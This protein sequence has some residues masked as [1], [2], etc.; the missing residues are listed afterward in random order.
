MKSYER[1]VIGGDLRAALFAYIH[2]L[3]LFFSNPIAPM[4]FEFFAP[5]VDISSLSLE[6]C[7][8]QLRTPAGTM[9]VG[10]SKLDVWERLIFLL[11]LGGNLPL[12]NLCD[13]I[14]YDGQKV[15]CTDEYAK[16][17]EFNFD[18]CYYFGDSNT[19]NLSEQSAPTIGK[20]VCYDYIA[21]HRGGKQEVDYISTSDDF[22][23]EIWLYSSDRIDGNTGVKD[24]CVVSTLTTEQLSD[25][26]YSQT[27]ARFKMEKALLDNG[28]RGPLNGYSSTGRPK[29]YNFKTSH[30]S[31][32]IVEPHTPQVSTVRGVKIMEISE[33]ALMDEFKETTMIKYRGLQ[34]GYTSPE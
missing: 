14:R 9:E 8:Q 5:S 28:L 7:L 11:S 24:A 15:V 26:N 3:P 34:C 22:V 16:I 21:L 13:K 12:A 25:P 19:T 29:H 17:Y 10:A 32:K 23:G 6:N 2:D 31:R 20:S 4:R 33:S 18:V 27:M 1:I 30:L